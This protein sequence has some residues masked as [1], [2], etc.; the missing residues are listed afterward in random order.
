M[1]V[2]LYVCVCFF[3]M[4]VF[5]FVSF[6]VCLCY[7]YTSLCLVLNKQTTELLQ[8]CLVCGFSNMD[9]LS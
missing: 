1:D 2:D 3:C 7:L 4:L 8:L 5:L 6:Y 9:F